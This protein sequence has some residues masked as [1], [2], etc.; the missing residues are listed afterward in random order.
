MFYPLYFR[1]PNG[2]G[3]ITKSKKENSW[4][5]TKYIL[6]GERELFLNEKASL[7]KI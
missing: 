7:D 5:V 1:P 6:E 4:V 2:K 3:W